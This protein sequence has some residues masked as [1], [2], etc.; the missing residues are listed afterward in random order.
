[1]KQEPYLDILDRLAKETGIE[2]YANPNQKKSSFIVM[3][4]RA[5]MPEYYVFDIPEYKDMH[6][7]FSDKRSMRHGSRNP[8]YG[9][10]MKIP[11]CKN[12]IRIRK[13]FMIDWLN[14]GKNNKTGNSTIDKR[15]IIFKENNERIPIKINPSTIMS[16]INVTK[17]IFPIY[18][19]TVRE[20]MSSVPVLNGENWVCLGLNDRWELDVKKLKYLVSKGSDYLISLI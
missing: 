18:I 20:S 15:V 10:Y 1:M 19:T 11:I 4:E 7:V 3:D 5:I 9:L 12:E 13:R 14:F 17:G 16:F 6:L 2:Y 8:Y